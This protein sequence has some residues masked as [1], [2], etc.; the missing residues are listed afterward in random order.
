MEYPSL[1]S[2]LLR[3]SRNT[4]PGQRKFAVDVAVDVVHIR[5]ALHKRVVDVGAVD[6][7][8]AADIGVQ[9]LQFGQCRGSSVL[10]RRAYIAAG[11]RW[12]MRPG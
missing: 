3:L 9:R 2:A 8:P 7:Q 4:A 12:Q 11:P 6:G 1:K 5:R 10:G